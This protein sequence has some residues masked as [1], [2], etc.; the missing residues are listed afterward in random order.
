MNSILV[1][2]WLEGLKRRVGVQQLHKIPASKELQS[3]GSLVQIISS[4]QYL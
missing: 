4:K 1:N 3:M 2:R